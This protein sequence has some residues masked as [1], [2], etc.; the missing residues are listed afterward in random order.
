MECDDP[1]PLSILHVGDAL[2]LLSLSPAQLSLHSYKGS[3]TDLLFFRLRPL[4]AVLVRVVTDGFRYPVFSLPNDAASC[5]AFARWVAVVGDHIVRWPFPRVFRPLYFSAQKLVHRVYRARQTSSSSPLQ[6]V[7]Y[8]CIPV[9]AR[10]LLRSYIQLV[11]FV[12]GDGPCR[13]P[14]PAP[15]LHAL[16]LLL[17]TE[18]R[19]TRAGGFR[20]MDYEGYDLDGRPSPEI[21][22]RVWQHHSENYSVFLALCPPPPAH[23]PEFLLLSGEFFPVVCVVSFLI[24][25][26]FSIARPFSSRGAWRFFPS[27][28]CFIFDIRFVVFSW[29][30]MS[31]NSIVRS[32]VV[33]VCFVLFTFL[34]IEPE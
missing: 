9:Q 28:V 32:F 8:F 15:H 6:A 7:D 1:P 18:C 34:K 24:S 21:C 29:R 14:T 30:R 13:V 16:E 27:R 22:H 10:A 25:L 23:Y 12:S 5:V 3:L 31:L 17:H 19:M 33:L 26:F 20:E 4:V 2:S 11:A